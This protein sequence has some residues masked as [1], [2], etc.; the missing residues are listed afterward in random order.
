MQWVKLNAHTDASGI[1]LW[2]RYRSNRQSGNRSR[3]LVF[4]GSLINDDDLV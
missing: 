1:V 3:N 4:M 2:M